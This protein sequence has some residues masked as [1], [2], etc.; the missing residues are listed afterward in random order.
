MKKLVFILVCLF[1]V[2]PCQAR[3]IYV[4]VNTPDNNDG[5]TPETAFA[6]IQ[7]AIDVAVDGDEVMVAGG[8]YTGLGNKNL[9]FGGRAIRVMSENGPEFTI[10]DCEYS[11]RGF[12]FHS[13]EEPNSVVAGFTITNG[14][15]P[16]AKINGIS[17]HPGGAIF[18]DNRLFQLPGRYQA[19]RFCHWRTPGRSPSL[20]I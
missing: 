12:Y 13:K 9:D 20:R 10:I 14:R 2:I 18:C 15:A 3:I 1:F 6:T 19:G 5:G 11:G 4:D 17:T 16:H 7:K 8:T